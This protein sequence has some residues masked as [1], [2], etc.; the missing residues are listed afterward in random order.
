MA[1]IMGTQNLFPH[2]FLSNFQ[3]VFFFM[4][5]VMGYAGDGASAKTH[6]YINTFHIVLCSLHIFIVFHHNIYIL[7]L[8]FAT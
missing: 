5:H 4:F 6:K 2:A 3:A 7:N 1:A 8:V